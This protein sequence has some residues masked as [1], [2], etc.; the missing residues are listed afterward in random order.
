MSHLLFKQCA[1]NSPIGVPSLQKN[2]FASL[3]STKYVKALIDYRYRTTGDHVD[4]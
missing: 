2:L 1:I 3:S 4:N